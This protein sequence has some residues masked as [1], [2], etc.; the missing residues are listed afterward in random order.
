M[1]LAELG[2]L[3]AANWRGRED[4]RQRM[5]RSKR[6][7]GNNDAEANALAVEISKCISKPVNGRPNARGGVF[8]VMGHSARRHYD[9]GRMLGATPDGRL[10]GEEFSKNISPTIGADTEGVTALLNS[11]AVLDARDFPGD[12]PL[13]VGLVASTI[14]GEKGVQVARA[15]IESYFDRG[16]LVI[17]FNVADA[18]VLRDAQ[19][20][21]EKYAN[22]QV[23]VCGW[24]V[25]WNDI[26]PVEQ[27]KFILRQETAAGF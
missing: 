19:R 22:L 14:A 27:E 24:N 11:A 9:F 25:R 13:D 10:K 6:K 1:S 8:K 17:Q 16:G 2:R 3:M 21:P 4:L 26:P 15:F 23:R 20:H 7:W 12:F 18:A 5:L